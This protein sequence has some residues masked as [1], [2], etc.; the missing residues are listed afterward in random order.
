MLLFTDAE[1]PY[2]WVNI[3]DDR[4]RTTPDAEVL[5]RVQADFAAARPSTVG[6]IDP[7]AVMNWSA[8]PWLKGHMA[9]RAPGQIARFRMNV[10]DPHG[11]IHFAGEHTAVLMAGM[12]GAMESGERAALEILQRL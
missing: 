10:A 11:R 9:Y 6:C 2:L 3:S 7:L 4:Y 5:Q 8:H 12:E 1:H